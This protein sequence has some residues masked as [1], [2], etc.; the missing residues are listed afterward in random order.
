MYNFIFKYIKKAFSF[1]SDLFKLTNQLEEKRP[2][3]RILSCPDQ[4]DRNFHFQII[5]KN[6]ALKAL[7]EKIM[8]DQI[9]LGFSRA[10]VALI[11][12]HGTKN[13]VVLDKKNGSPKPFK[14][15]K[16]I[17]TSGKKRFLIENNDGDVLE[18][19]TSELFDDPSMVKNF[20]A[21]DGVKI[22][23]SAAEEYFER[24]KLLG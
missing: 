1:S 21:A 18:Y 6:V 9:L 7:P 14:I 11:A 3:Y 12:Y 23:Y 10:D 19:E 8:R 16:E 20:T 5:G 24:M 22:G 15:I 2:F 17:F 13:E 4:R